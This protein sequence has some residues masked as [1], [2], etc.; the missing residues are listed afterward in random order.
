[1]N[2]SK[3]FLSTLIAAAAMSSAVYADVG[4]NKGSIQWAESF[5]DGYS[6]AATFGM[7]NAFYV[8]N[9]YGVAGGNHANSRVWTTNTGGKFTNAF[10]FSFELVDFDANN[11]TDA[12]ALYTNGTKSGENN[13]IQLQKNANNELMVYTSNFTGSNV[14]GDDSNINLGSIA[15][16]KGKVIT[17]S[18]DGTGATKTLTAYVDGVANTDTVTFTYAEDVTPSTALTGFQFGAAFGNQR[19]SNSVTVDNIVVSNT[20][21]C[22]VQKNLDWAEG[23]AGSWA[24]ATWSDGQS[25]G[26][27]V[28]AN[29]TFGSSVTMTTDTNVWLGSLNVSGG[30]TLTLVAGKNENGEVVPG[31][32]MLSSA[33]DLV[34][35]ENAMLDLGS[36]VTL[37]LGT[38]NGVVDKKISGEG[39]L[40]FVSASSGHSAGIK[41]ADDFTGVVDFAGKL[42]VANVTLGAGATLKLSKYAAHN[43]SSLWGNGTLACHV[44]FQTDYQLGDSSGATF[45]LSGDVSV[46]GGKVLRVGGTKEVANIT[47]SGSISGEEGSKLEVVKDRGNATISG[48][49]NGTLEKVGE[50]AL[51]VSGSVASGATLNVSGGTTT[52]TCSGP[53]GNGGLQ[54][55]LIVGSGAKVIGTGGDAIPWDDNANHEQVVKVLGTLELNARWSMNTNKKLVLAGGTVSGSGAL[56]QGHSNVVLDYFSGGTISTEEG[57]TGSKISGNILFKDGAL[58]FSVASDSDLLVSGRINTYAGTGKLIKTGTGTLTL[59]SANT[60]TGGTTISSGTLVMGNRNALGA[61][62]NA[63]V[64]GENAVL[65]LKGELDQGIGQYTYTLQGGTLEYGSAAG[66]VDMSVNWAQFK[67]GNNAVTEI[68]KLEADSELNVSKKLGFVSANYYQNKLNLGGYTLTKTGSAALG[69]CNTTIST[70]TLAIEEGTVEIWKSDSGKITTA[71]DAAIKISGGS[72]KLDLNAHDFSVGSLTLEVS[73]SYTDATLLGSGKLTIGGDGRIIIK[74]SEASSLNLAAET[75]Y[76]FQIAASGA[77]FDDAWTKDSFKLE[78]WTNDWYIA[79]YSNG[80]LTLTIPEPSTF[81]LL[82]GLGALTL[83]GTRRRRKKA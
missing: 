13:S 6:Q 69:L 27:N 68:V 33:D 16:L 34:L 15:N 1:M 42:N 60:Y 36:N 75:A 62:G 47:F 50:G 59:S 32:V 11:W 43:Y 76:T 29:V 49:I 38:Y 80:Q 39:T 71:A 72:G 45:E 52:I 66:S 26:N 83:V 63:I 35:G 46:A 64:I 48:T 79:D 31:A 81:G 12:L 28:I 53:N 73:D 58:E 55:N 2:T 24:D 7:N 19:V 8:E 14:T 67:G 30:E 41:L 74:R 22:I 9:G 17:L 44:L 70:G 61:N 10:T 77:T 78:G 57:T 40:K 65:K 25:I 21:Q 5:G 23:D 4:L 18:F 51:T 56:H 3:F 37:D 20:A 54:G 82:A